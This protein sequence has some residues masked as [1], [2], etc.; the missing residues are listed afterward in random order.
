MIAVL[1]TLIIRA[2]C[3]TSCC[4]GETAGGEAGTDFGPTSGVRGRRS[5][6]GRSGV[7]QCHGSCRG[8]GT[9]HLRPRRAHTAGPIQTEAAHGK[10]HQVAPSSH[11]GKPHGPSRN[12]RA[13]RLCDLSGDTGRLC[14]SGLRARPVGPL[15]VVFNARGDASISIRYWTQQADSRR[16]IIYASKEYSNALIAPWDSSRY[17][18]N[19]GYNQLLASDYTDPNLLATVKASIDAAVARLPVDASRIILTGFSGGA[20]L[21][22]P[23]RLV[24]GFATAVIDNSNGQP[25]LYQSDDESH[26]GPS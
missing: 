7:A 12:S 6:P 3:E 19:P 14:P 23:Q 22:R 8:P 24:P 18:A 10:R 16:W 17:A 15:L 20:F 4:P 5:G 2:A 13:E 21:P 1:G 25:L 9:N 11:H 26:G